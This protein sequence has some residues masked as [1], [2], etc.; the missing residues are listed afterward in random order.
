[1]SLIVNALRNLAVAVAVVALLGLAF[2]IGP[3]TMAVVDAGYRK[4][5]DELIPAR[6]EL[7]NRRLDLES[8][9]RDRNQDLIEVSAKIDSVSRRLKEERDPDLQ[10]DLE[11]LVELQRIVRDQ[12]LDLD[13]SIKRAQSNIDELSRVIDRAHGHAD[14]VYLVVRGIAL[15][16]LGALLCVSVG[17]LSRR[18]WSELFAEGDFERAIGAALVGAVAAVVAIALFHTRQVSIFAT[19]PDEAAGRPDFWR[20]TIL[21]L[22][23]GA[24]AGAVY[25][26]NAPRLD[27]LLAPAPG[28]EPEP[29]S[30]KPAHG[31]DDQAQPD[32]EGRQSDPEE[33]APE[34]RP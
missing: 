3:Q 20:V 17:A 34:P 14:N 30:V 5:S 4:A 16:A 10:A 32:A 28:P 12:M 22:G 1:M 7:V 18:R 2:F 6:T 29:K 27:R 25:R 19:S 13:K 23:A 31:E 15:G 8:D 26:R 21:C 33:P 11:N 24:V 9:Y